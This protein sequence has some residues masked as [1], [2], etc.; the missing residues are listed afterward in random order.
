MKRYRM[1]SIFGP[2]T[3]TQDRI[4]IWDRIAKLFGWLDWVALV[5]D[6]NAERIETK[7]D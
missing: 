2:T 4:T 5:D 6:T 1:Y 7:L 3:Y